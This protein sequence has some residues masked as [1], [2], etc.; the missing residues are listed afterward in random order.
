LPEA[1]EDT[2]GA[3]SSARTMAET[4]AKFKALNMVEYP[5]LDECQLNE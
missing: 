1:A 4:K 5:L 2:T 3:A